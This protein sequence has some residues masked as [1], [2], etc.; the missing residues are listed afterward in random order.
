VLLWLKTFEKSK[1]PVA[2]IT[3][4]DTTKGLQEFD[5][6]LASIKS[7]PAQLQKPIQPNATVSSEFSR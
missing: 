5:R 6:F 1:A 2:P 4:K 3:I 7:K